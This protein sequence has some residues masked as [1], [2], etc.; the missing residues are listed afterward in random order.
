MKKMMTSLFAGAVAL[1]MA[2]AAVAQT[3]GVSDTEV[4]LG[5]VNDLSGIFAAVGVPAV[6]AAN[7]RFDQANAAGGIHGRQ[8]RFVVEDHAYQLPKSTQAYNKLINRDQVFANLLSLGTPH[9]LAGFQLMDPKG[10]F[11][12]NPLTAARE[13]LKEPVDNKFTGFSSYYDQTTAGMRYLAKEYGLTKVCTMYLPTDFGLEIS[14]A[15]KEQ[16]EGLGMTFV[17]ETTHKPDEQEF[18]GAVQ[19][20]RS[21]GCEVVTMALGVRAGI[22]VVGTAKQLGWT[23]VKFLATSAGFLEAV[24]AVPGG[25]TDG[26]YAASGWVDLQARRDDPAPA[27][28]I[29]EYEAAFGQPAT[30]FAML[31]YNAADTVVR[32]LEAAGPDLTQDSFRAAMEGLEYYSDLLDTQIKY[33]PDNH[34]GANDITISVV[35]GGLWKLVGRE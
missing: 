15:T 14:N 29:A 35:E 21:D 8:I 30:G 27:K 16:A 32:A 34:Q 20:L 12:I 7:L 5:S 24:A 31:G 19:K 33:G 23:D 6:N 28:F 22:T 4:V 11:N 17:S 18:V 13:M 3:Q 25:V 26:L 10:V 1:G 2:Q 9:N